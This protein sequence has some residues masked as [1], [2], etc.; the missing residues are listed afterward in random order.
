[1]STDTP[2]FAALAHPVRRSLI[3][4]LAANS[5]R[6][7]T[8]LARDYAITRQGIRK[9][10]QILEKASLVVVSQEGRDKRYSLTP[11]PLSEVDQWIREISQE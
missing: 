7:A 2:V 8:Q 1:L 3:V 10:L 4:N 6:T 11:T 9:H 5:P